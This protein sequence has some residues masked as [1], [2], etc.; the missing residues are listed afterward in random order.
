MSL[1]QISALFDYRIKEGYFFKGA[2]YSL[3]TVFVYSLPFIPLYCIT[4]KRE[5]HLDFV[6]LQV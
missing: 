1:L 3:T 4:N 6:H 2:W 5:Y